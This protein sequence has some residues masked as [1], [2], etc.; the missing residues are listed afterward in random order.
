[1][2]INLIN[3]YNKKNYVM[4]KDKNKAPKE[5]KSWK[6]K[7]IDKYPSKDWYNVKAPIFFV[8]QQIATTLVTRTNDKLRSQKN[9][10]GRIFEVSLADL[11]GCEDKALFKVKLRVEQICGQDCYTDFCGL[12]L[13]KDKLGSLFKKGQ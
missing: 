1:M 13:T 3:K 12:E 5:N 8:N 11:Q 2:G 9:I 4:T 10:K 7:F 6:K